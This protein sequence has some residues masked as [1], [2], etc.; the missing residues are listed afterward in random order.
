M[1]DRRKALNP[2]KK[3]DCVREFFCH[4]PRVLLLGLLGLSCVGCEN[5]GQGAVSGAG[6]GALSGL[7]IGSLSGNAGKGA[8]IGAVVGGVGGA[9]IGDQNRR[10]SEQAAA[11][12]KLA[13]NPPPPPPS[14]LPPPPLP[15]PPPTGYVVQT[16]RTGS[17]LGRLVGQWRISGV[18]DD[19]R[20]GSLPVYGNASAAVENVY[21][22]R[23]SIHF[24]DPRTN[25]PVDGTSVISQD[26]DRRLEMTNSFSSS[27]ETKKFVGEMDASGSVLNLRQVSPPGTD[28]QVVIRMSNSPGWTA[29]V[30]LGQKRLESYSFSPAQP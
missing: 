18:V 9:V 3:R 2:N 5:A 17:S 27:P 20:G 1:F 25:M 30:W 13:A 7:A 19:G 14:P 12:A 24:V 29:D 4:G 11:D 15:P 28:R 6:I 21:F 23:I 16:Y 8:A 22:V 26:G 10:N